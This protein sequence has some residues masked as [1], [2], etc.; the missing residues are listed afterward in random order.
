VLPLREWDYPQLFRFAALMTVIW[1]PC[2]AVGGFAAMV[3]MHSVPASPGAVFPWQTR[4]IVGA[5]GAL[6]V[7][8]I[9]GMTIGATLRVFLNEAR[10]RRDGDPRVAR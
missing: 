4:L 3:L 1:V 2:V 8:I 6:V 5:L 9:P 10:W 7:V